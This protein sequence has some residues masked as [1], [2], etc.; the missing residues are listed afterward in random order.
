MK[1]NEITTPAPSTPKTP[2]QQRIAG[3]QRQKQVAS[4][5]LKAERNRQKI[6]KAQ[7]QIAQASATAP[8]V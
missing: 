4:D 2:Q 7:L 3:L 6:H 1:I 5:A 8:V